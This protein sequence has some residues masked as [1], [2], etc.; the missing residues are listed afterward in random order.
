[1]I[2]CAPK[3]STVTAASSSQVSVTTLN[4]PGGEVK[5]GDTL[6]Q[7]KK[8]FPPPVDARAFDAPMSFGV[9]SKEGWA[10]SDEAKS[11][12][13][14]VATKGG[15]IVALGRVSGK[16]GNEPGDSI[17]KLGKPTHQADGKTAAAYSW[18]SGSDARFLLTMKEQLT[19]MP[20]SVL[21][22]IGAKE[23]LKLLNYR[24]DEPGTFVKQLDAAADQLSSPEPKKVSDAR[25][26][27]SGTE[28]KS[29]Y[30]GAGNS[31]GTRAPK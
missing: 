4:G 12:G 15:K 10:W 31:I 23:D 16:P 6:K 11:E 5:L 21:L 19:L 22:V 13:F 28:A 2:G 18:E 8:A 30:F 17:A 29:F 3:S 7:A 24:S 26:E 14:E 9:I 1:M 25:K 27:P 20:F